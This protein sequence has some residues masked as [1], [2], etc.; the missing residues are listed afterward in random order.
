MRDTAQPIRSGPEARPKKLF[1]LGSITDVNLSQ[2]SHLYRTAQP[3]TLRLYLQF[4]LVYRAIAP[5]YAADCSRR[6]SG[7]AC[8]GTTSW[9]TRIASNPTSRRISSIRGAT[10]H[11]LKVWPASRAQP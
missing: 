9:Q 4:F 6:A 11:T 3:K 8:I 5:A 2:A 1:A 7:G 10:L